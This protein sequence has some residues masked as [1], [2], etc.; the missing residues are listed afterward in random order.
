MVRQINIIKAQLRQLQESVDVIMN[1]SSNAVEGRLMQ[2]AFPEGL[3]PIDDLSSLQKLQDF[4]N[5]SKA[6]LVTLLWI[7]FSLAR[8]PNYNFSFADCRTSKRHKWHKEIV[9]CYAADPK[10]I[11]DR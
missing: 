6:I 11:D 9:E 2:D 1:N 3:L 10:E 4:V 7:L 8:T 5:D